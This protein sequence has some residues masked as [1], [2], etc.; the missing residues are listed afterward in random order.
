MFTWEMYESSSFFKS[1]SELGM[2]S[3]FNKCVVVSYCDFNCISLIIYDTGHFFMVEMS[4]LL[5]KI[6]VV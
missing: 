6:C 4:F 2:I 5:S 1:S 3:H